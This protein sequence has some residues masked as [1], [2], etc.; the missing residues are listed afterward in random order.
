MFYFTC[1]HGLT[2]PSCNRLI[3]DD[4][5]MESN[6]V[7]ANIIW[8]RH[9]KTRASRTS[10]AALGNVQ[11]TLVKTF[12][13]VTSP[14]LNWPTNW[15]ATCFST[16]K[17]CNCHSQSSAPDQSTKHCHLY[18]FMKAL[19]KSIDFED[20]CSCS[21]RNRTSLWQTRLTRGRNAA[22][23]YRKQCNSTD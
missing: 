23:G 18:H 17:I 11:G 1:N 16:G 19:Y 4:L 20:E 21:S 22:I 7:Q 6:Y 3:H 13:T 12:K 5:Q 14:R 2:D 10:Y 15:M 8:R 9:E